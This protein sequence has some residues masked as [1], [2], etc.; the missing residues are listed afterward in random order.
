M[1]SSPP[2]SVSLH[3]KAAMA[4]SACKESFRD[5]PDRAREQSSLVQGIFQ[6]LGGRESEL[7]GCRD[8]DRRS[9]GRIAC[10]SFRRILHL[11]LAEARNGSLG[12]PAAVVIAEK[13]ASTIALLCTLVRPWLVRSCRRFHSLSSPALA[14]AGLYAPWLEHRRSGSCTSNDLYES[15]AANRFTRVMFRK[16]GFKWSRLPGIVG[17]GFRLAAALC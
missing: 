12:D 11:E 1:E 3:A 5:A 9:R 4:A 13:T 15:I 7:F 2:D 16:G 8:L 10:L 6:R 14:R 17:P